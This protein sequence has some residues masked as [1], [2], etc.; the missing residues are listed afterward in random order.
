M[1][2]PPHFPPLPSVPRFILHPRDSLLGAI[3]NNGTF[4][5]YHHFLRPA[6]IPHSRVIA[7]TSLLKGKKL[8]V[9]TL[10]EWILLY[11]AVLVTNS[12]HHYFRKSLHSLLIRALQLTFQPCRHYSGFKCHHVLF[13]LWH[14][15]I[16]Q[17]AG[18]T[19]PILFP[20]LSFFRSG[21]PRSI[22]LPLWNRAG[23]DAVKRKQGST[24]LSEI[25]SCSELSQHLWKEFNFINLGDEWNI[26]YI[27]KN[28]STQILHKKPKTYLR[29]W[30]GTQSVHRPQKPDC[31]WLHH[32]IADNRSKSCILHWV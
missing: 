27:L 23:T 8:N 20:S 15:L 2:L 5:K 18:E 3:S 10:S 32:L 12:A 22:H 4:F 30:M 25:C 19:P 1:M 17:E 26:R 6:Y 11:W 24:T 9:F 7:S 14:S 21:I 13:S 29:S 16:L 28:G 31:K